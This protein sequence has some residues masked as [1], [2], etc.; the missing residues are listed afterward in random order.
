MGDN[1]MLWGRNKSPMRDKVNPAMANSTDDRQQE[2]AEARAG[3]SDA[4]LAAIV[5]S[6]DD[7]IAS[8]DLDGRI[9]SWNKSAEKLFGYSAQEIVG[10]PITTIIPPERLHEEDEIL[11]CLRRGERI[12]HFETQRRH[13]DGHLI[14]VSVTISPVRNEQGKVAGASKVVRDITEQKRNAQTGALL[15]A[16]VDSSDDAIVSKD[17]NSVITSWNT[18]AVKM[19][20]YTASEAIGR[21]IW[22]LFP[23]ERMAEEKMILDRIKRGECIEHYE[24]VRM[25]KDGSLIDVS[26]TVSPVKDSRGE[27]IGV[28]KIA[29]DITESRRALRALEIARRD[30]EHANAQLRA[31][32]SGL[33]E[34]VREKTAEI[35][36]SRQDWEAFAYSI[37]HDLRAHI[38]TVT[39]FSQMLRD[40][41]G[42]KLTGP[43]QDYLA[44]IGRA[45]DRMREL[46][47]GVLAFTKVAHAN[48][49]LHSVSLDNAV[50][51]VVESTPQLQAPAAEVRIHMPLGKVLAN[52]IGLQQCISNLLLNA[53]K[54]VAKDVTPLVNIRSETRGDMLRLWIED[55][56]I[57][58]PAEEQANVFTI[59]Q[60]SANA[61]GYEG[62]GVGLAIVRRVAERLQGR[63]GVESE[64]GKGSRFWIEFKV[65]E[66]Q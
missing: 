47:N 19:F 20:G 21:P 11:R 50:R 6:S 26:L 24:T 44:R 38:R 51:Q 49:G 28:S 53:A 37:S 27:V 48:L 66:A 52:V 2:S 46:V 39:N 3:S 4:L 17:L 12:D 65:P 61:R 56:G 16:I 14:D 30:L 15:A 36:Q 32:T 59:F 58:I 18:G 22:M 29:R 25:R 35:E 55:N 33:E 23:P 5:D 13:K 63:A 64:V 8:K 57:G 10:L 42:K 1:H 7:A 9:T 60:R 45:A 54:Y 40:E 34:R 41:A 62:S 43:E 31:L